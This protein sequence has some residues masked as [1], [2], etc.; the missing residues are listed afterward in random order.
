M[1]KNKAGKIGENLATKKYKKQS[2]TAEVIHRLLKNK[3]AVVGLCIISLII[4]AFIAS[5]F[6]IDYAMI[7]EG[8]VKNKQIPPSSQY[9]FGTDQYGRDLFYRV[10]YGARYSL[11]IGFGGSLIA[12]VFGVFLGCLA[13]YYGGV[14]DL[15]IMRLSEVLTSI[16]GML[17]GMVI[18]L[19]L[20]SNLLNLILCIGFTSIPVYIRMSRAS[21]LSIRNEEYV[22]AAQAIGL[23]NLRIIFT[24]ILPNGLSPLIVTFTMNI[25]MMIL[26]SSGLSFLGF[27]IAPPLPEWG[28]LIA[29]S[30]EYMRNSGYLLTIPGL[31][32]MATV[33]AFN[34]FGD[35]LRDALDPKLKT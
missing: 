10:L 20:G 29:G 28:T 30:R 31:F 8:S 4:L 3:G 24:H 22:E 34:M 27:G 7:T 12:I 16:P 9:L 33:L 26:T 13:G 32:I 5:L 17:L 19:T 1:K 14:C 21:I 18:M 25:G 2:L 11:A 15:L 23:R 6:F 35:G